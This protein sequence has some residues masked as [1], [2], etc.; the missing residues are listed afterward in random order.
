MQ[1]KE[2]KRDWKE[3]EP[4]SHRRKE[5]YEK[6]WIKYLQKKKE[7][8]QNKVDQY[9]IKE[10]NDVETNSTKIR[11]QKRAKEDNKTASQQSHW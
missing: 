2:E 10:K 4:I 6:N 11:K 3:T 1:Q 5:N 8:H 7:Y 9:L